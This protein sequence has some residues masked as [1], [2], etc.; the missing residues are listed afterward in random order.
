[1]WSYE[2]EQIL[3]LSYFLLLVII[4]IEDFVFGKIFNFTI[5]W[6]IL[7]RIFIFFSYNEKITPSIGKMFQ[8]F[9]IVIIFFILW[10]KN[11]I[12]GGDLKT[13]LLFLF[14][15]SVHSNKHTII[16]PYQLFDRVQFFIS[17]FMIIFFSKLI[18]KKKK[19]S[20]ISKLGPIFLISTS[21]AILF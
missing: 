5:T 21:I 14:Y 19:H 3:L 20:P 7:L 1:M 2:S 4:S 13:I 6:G 8:N 15:I 18:Q 11:I 17:F 12:G 10:N 9:I 16:F